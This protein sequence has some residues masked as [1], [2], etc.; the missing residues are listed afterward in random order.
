MNEHHWQAENDPLVLLG[1][2]FPQHSQGTPQHQTRKCR[3]YLAACARRRWDRLPGVCRALVALAEACAEA[4][5]ES[6]R[7]AEPIRRAAA[8]IAEGLMHSDGEPTALWAAGLELAKAGRDSVNLALALRAV[9]DPL[10]ATPESPL[11]R[12]E[13]HGLA[14]LVYLP[15][16]PRTP[17][18]I[19]VP[20]D[21]HAAGLV[22]EIYYNPTLFPAFD[23]AWRTADVRAI[24]QEMY[25]SRD[26]G[27]MPILADA[28]QDAGCDDADVLNHCRKPGEH[29]RGCRV[30]D[31]VLNR[32]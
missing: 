9:P 3:L 16:V 11:T 6:P 13:W 15:F 22:R 1:E 8:P 5:A 14:A 24:A 10:D 31:K 7:Q 21:L 30:I 28:L 20:R 26:F 23:P 18:F 19:W 29:V 32:G 27:A 17:P 2:L 12:G 25:D 4:C